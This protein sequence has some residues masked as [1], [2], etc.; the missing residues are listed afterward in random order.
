MIRSARSSDLPAVLAMV[1]KL[2]VSTRQM[3]PFDGD[4]TMRTLLHL[5]TGSRSLLAVSEVD[6]RLNG[7]VAATVAY[8]SVSTVPFAQEHGWWG[9]GGCGLRLLKHYEK[10]AKG[11]GCSFARMCTPP[12]N[13]M[14][15]KLL[16]KRGY[17]LAELVW[18]KAI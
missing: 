12:H 6:E 13:E 11:E 3:A 8:G 16:E 18:V 2:H 1:R 17:A 15:A 5:M 10:W 14:A 4:M 9:E 7:F